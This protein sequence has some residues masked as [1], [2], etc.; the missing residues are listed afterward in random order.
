ML[1]KGAFG[2]VWA[3]TWKVDGK[4]Y[5][6][7]KVSRAP[8]IECGM[9][10]QL[11]LEVKLMA[12]LD[13]PNIIKCLGWWEDELNL[14]LMLEFAAKGQLFNLVKRYGKVS[15]G[16]AVFYIADLC[17]ALD[18]MHHFDNGKKQ[19]LHRDIKGENI[20]IMADGHSKLADFGWAGIN[21]GNRDRKTYCGTPEYLAPEVVLQ[22]FQTYAVD[23]WAIGILFYELLCGVTP[24]KPVM[25]DRSMDDN[26]RHKRVPKSL[27]ITP[28]AYQFINFI[29]EKDPKMRPTVTQV[30]DHKFWKRYPAIKFDKWQPDA[31]ILRMPEP[32][33]RKVVSPNSQPSKINQGTP[34]FSPGQAN[35]PGPPAPTR[36]PKTYDQP[37]P[38]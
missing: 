12:Q 20:L 26:I 2:E 14:W 10:K 38:E 33:K 30:M 28:Q 35:M 36:Q 11:R 5:A 18:Y 13:H 7:K 32:A 9:Q 34:Q 21:Q 19:I 29:L 4:K 37:K 27:A 6:L 15:E 17:K 31:S 22:Q 1:G 8:I 24:F 16:N 25:G 3:G 23:T